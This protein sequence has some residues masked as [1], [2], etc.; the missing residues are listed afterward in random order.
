MISVNYQPLVKLHAWRPFHSLI[1]Q[2]APKH[3]SFSYLGMMSRFVELCMHATGNVSLHRLYL[4]ALHYNYNSNRKQAVTKKGKKR[5]SMLF[6]KYK[7]G[8]HIVRKIKNN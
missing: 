5:F 4:A 7:K 3:T 2:Y 8:G 1:N 6:P